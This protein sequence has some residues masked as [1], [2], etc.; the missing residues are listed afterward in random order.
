MSN[1]FS[2]WLDAGAHGYP[3]LKSF[4]RFILSVVIA[5]TILVGFLSLVEGAPTLAACLAV[6]FVVVWIVWTVWP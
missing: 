5:S 6:P 2:N 3:S 4:S 1:K